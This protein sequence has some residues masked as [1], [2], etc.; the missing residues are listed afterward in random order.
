M[1]IFVDEKTIELANS[2]SLNQMAELIE[3][4]SDRISVYVGKSQDVLG[5][6]NKNCKDRP[7]FLI[8]SELDKR[9]PAVTNGATIQINLDLLGEYNQEGC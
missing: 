8:D 1:S 3:L 7:N 9:L 5:H 6:I 4:F 2:I